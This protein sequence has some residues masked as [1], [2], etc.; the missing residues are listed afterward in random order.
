MSTDAPVPRLG[1]EESIEQALARLRRSRAEILESLQTLH[2][3]RPHKRRRDP[4]PRSAIM[5]AALG[6]NGRMVLGGAAVT[7]A[8]LRPRL[9]PMVVRFARLAPLIP[10]VRILLNRYLVRRNSPHE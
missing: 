9:I 1:R 5:R 8:V 6:H 4:F 3:P 7:L 10:V 2:V